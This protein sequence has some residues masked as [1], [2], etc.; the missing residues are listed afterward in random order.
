MVAVGI[1][2]VAFELGAGLS[3]AVAGALDEAVA[4][5]LAEA[6]AL[7][8]AAAVAQAAQGAGRG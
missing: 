4:V 7:E 1:E 3:P 8:G 6:R 5:V 2:G